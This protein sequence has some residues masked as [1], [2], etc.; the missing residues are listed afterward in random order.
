M[1]MG[2]RKNIMYAYKSLWLFLRLYTA[3]YVKEQIMIIACFFA[4]I[5]AFLWCFE[6]TQHNPWAWSRAPLPLAAE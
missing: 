4:G 6:S 2:I 3:T 5:S 1:G